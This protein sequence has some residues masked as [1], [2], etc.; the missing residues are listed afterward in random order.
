MAGFLKFSS[1]YL[2]QRQFLLIGRP[3]NFC[4]TCITV[5]FLHENP[6][7]GWLR[8][9]WFIEKPQIGSP[10]CQWLEDQLSLVTSPKLDDVRLHRI[11]FIITQADRHV[12]PREGHLMIERVSLG[13]QDLRWRIIRGHWQLHFIGIY[14]GQTQ[15]LPIYIQVE[16]AYPAGRLIFH[17]YPVPVIGVD[18]PDQFDI[19]TASIGEQVQIFRSRPVTTAEAICS[20]CGV[21]AFYNWDRCGCK[22]LCGQWGKCQREGW[23]GKKCFRGD[24]RCRGRNACRCGSYSRHG[25]KRKSSAARDI[26]SQAQQDQCAK[27]GELFMVHPLIVLRKKS[28]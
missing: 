1:I 28:A 22:R 21:D 24:E 12:H 6:P 8:T 9:A 26:A 5:F 7:M 20:H 3:G 10:G 27:E 13:A 4:W 19:G 2:I 18:T 15:N 11:I 17:Q 16:G 25:G 14:N 23:A